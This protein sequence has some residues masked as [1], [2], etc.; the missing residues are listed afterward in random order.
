MVR[1]VALILL[2]AGSLAAQA[3]DGTAL[4][5]RIRQHVRESIV[6]VPNYTCLET[7]D[8]TTTGPKGH[9]EFRE[10]L[11]VEVLVADHKELFAWPGSTDF[12][13]ADFGNADFGNSMVDWIDAGAIGTGNFW[14]DLH[15]VFVASGT[16][17]SYAGL[18]GVDKSLYRFDFHVPSLSSRY[19][20]SIA[21]KTATTAYSGSFWVDRNSLD[22]VRLDTRAEDIPPDLDCREESTSATYGRVSL[23]GKERL[24]AS[25][26]ELEIVDRNSYRSHNAVVFTGCR[27]Y[28]AVSSLS[29]DDRPAS[30]TTRE[31]ARK[32]LKL[33]GDVTLALKMD[34]PI[35]ME[36]SAAGDEI[37][38]VLDKPVKSGDI[39]LAKGTRVLGRIRRLERYSR[40]RQ[41]G[42]PGAMTM[43]ALEFYAVD[44]REGLIRFKARLTGPVAMATERIS[45]LRGPEFTTGEEGLDIVDDGASSGVGRFRVPGKNLRLARGFRTLWKTE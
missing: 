17:V 12:A 30:S 4:L 31:G 19:I 5:I 6:D 37:V 41:F 43:V 32:E 3:I 27:H 16:S 7:M 14:T 40:A 2:A 22:L 15:N 39:L 33:P 28:G 38:A 44:S 23:G 25:A 11:R 10:R 34:G 45:R 1:L 13:D 24:L 35:T 21:G 26:S 18:A 9:E 20:L 42:S 36:E 8:R 29:F